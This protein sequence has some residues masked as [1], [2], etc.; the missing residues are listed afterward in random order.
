MHRMVAVWADCMSDINHI[1]YPFRWGPTGNA[2]E[3]EQ[4]TL[5]EITNCVEVVVRTS[6]GDLVDQPDMGITDPLFKRIPNVVQL[7]SQINQWEPRADIQLDTFFDT[8][9]TL[10]RY[11]TLQIAT[12][13]TL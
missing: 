12:R 2:A 13:S 6:V 10:I 3:L 5:D 1:S 11:I 7:S 8:V 4:D 9:D